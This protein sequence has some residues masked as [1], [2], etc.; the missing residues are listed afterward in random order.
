MYIK[1]YNSNWHKLLLCLH[2]YP[3][4]QTLTSENI[5]DEV[6]VC[7]E[8]PDLVEAGQSRDGNILVAVHLSLEKQVIAEVLSEE[9]RKNCW[10]HW[11]MLAMEGLPKIT[12]HILSD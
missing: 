8:I 1:Y 7:G 4:K 2:L 5:G 12:V 10:E 11:Y 3:Q 9:G 6:Q